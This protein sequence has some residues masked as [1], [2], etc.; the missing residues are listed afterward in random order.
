M[1]VPRAIPTPVCPGDPTREAFILHVPHGCSRNPPWPGPRNEQWGHQQEGGG[2]RGLPGGRGGLAELGGSP[3]A[4]PLT[5]VPWSFPKCSL[6]TSEGR[7][8]SHGETWLHSFKPPG[9]PQAVVQAAGRG[10][11][12][13]RHGCPVGVACVRARVGHTQSRAGRCQDPL[14]RARPGDRPPLGPTKPGLL[15]A[16]TLSTGNWKQV[17]P[18]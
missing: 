1:W 12:G 2:P 13:R 3:P 6:Q 4:G 7:G 15:L 10:A 11:E 8:G 18:A 17:G 5:R 14:V 16:G 9:R